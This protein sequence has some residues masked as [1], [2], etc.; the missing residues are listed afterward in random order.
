MSDVKEQVL[1]VVVNN[2]H[3]VVK[4]IKNNYCPFL[5]EVYRLENNE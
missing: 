3:I 2:K 5:S 1:K 4:K